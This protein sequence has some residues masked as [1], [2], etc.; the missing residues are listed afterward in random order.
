MALDV[1]KAVE[2]AGGYLSELLQIPVS[3]LLLEE[4]ERSGSSWKVTFS[5]PDRSPS[6]RTLVGG[7]IYKVVEVDAVSG[8]FVAV[9]IRAVAYDR[10]A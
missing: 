7:R 8:E 5:Y 4:V 10:S 9:R 1:K 2:L 3:D 6:L